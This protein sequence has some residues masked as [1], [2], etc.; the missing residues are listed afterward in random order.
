MT[1]KDFIELCNNDL[2]MDRP[3]VMTPGHDEDAVAVFTDE[4]GDINSSSIIA[5]LF[6]TGSVTVNV[7][8]KQ[9]VVYM[10]VEEEG[11]KQ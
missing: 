6:S 2:N 9:Y 5:E 4:D 3:S 1:W 10:R 8:E 7:G 11:M